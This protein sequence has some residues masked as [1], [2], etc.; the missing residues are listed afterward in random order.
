M[1]V[2]TSPIDATVFYKHSPEEVAALNA[3]TIPMADH[4]KAVALSFERSK[5]KAILAGEYFRAKDAALMRTMLLRAA[6]HA[7]YHLDEFFPMMR[8]EVI[9]SAEELEEAVLAY[10]QEFRRLQ[11]EAIPSH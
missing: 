9:T 4:I 7:R 2:Q 6:N 1:N 8:N 3:A 10:W 11:N 5:T